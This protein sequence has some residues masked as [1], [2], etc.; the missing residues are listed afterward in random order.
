AVI[1]CGSFANLSKID[2]VALNLHIKLQPQKCCFSGI[3]LQFWIAFTSSASQHNS[4]MRFEVGT[5]R[6]D[7][8]E[9]LQPYLYILMWP[10]QPM[11]RT[12]CQQ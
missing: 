5:V 4:H 3:F 6:T 10:Q 2:L 7:D 8:D 9:C 1:R 11:A 12:I